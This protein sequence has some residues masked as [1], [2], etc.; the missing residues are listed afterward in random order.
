MVYYNSLKAVD[1]LISAAKHGQRSAVCGNHSFIRG[2]DGAFVFRYFG[3]PVCVVPD[4]GRGIPV[5]DF[6]GYEGYSST[7][8]T[9]NSY[10]AE[11]GE[12]VTAA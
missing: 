5:Y 6:C 1:N 10:K 3:N 2:V 12:G 11:F 4:E 7:T 8:R 9:I